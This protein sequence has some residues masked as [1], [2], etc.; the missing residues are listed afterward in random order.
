MGTVSSESAYR[1]CGLGDG[2]VGPRLCLNQQN[3][4]DVGESPVAMLVLKALKVSWRTA[5]WYAERLV[6]EHSPGCQGNH[7]IEVMEKS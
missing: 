3:L 1:S 5:G 2:G 4:N 6:V 7:R